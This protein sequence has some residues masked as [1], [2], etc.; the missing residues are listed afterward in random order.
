ML[1][2]KHMHKL[3]KIALRV[4]SV[5][6]LIIAIF[7]LLS[8]CVQ[9]YLYHKINIWRPLITLSFIGLGFI[10]FYALWGYKKWLVVILGVNFVNVLSTQAL[11]LT[12]HGTCCSTTPSR[13]AIAILLSGS[14]LLLVYF[15]RHHLNGAYLKWLPILIFV[16]FILLNQISLRHLLGAW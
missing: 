9:I 2:F 12:Y 5:I 11:K 13:A 3:L 8:F 10:G 16:G 7:S 1:K 4:I 6:I 15:S 14:V